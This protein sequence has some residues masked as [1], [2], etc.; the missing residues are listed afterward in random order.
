MQYMVIFTPAARFATEGLPP[1]F[2][3]VELEEQA[4][5]QAR[6]LYADGRLRQTWALGGPDQH[7][8]VVLFEA[9]DREDLEAAIVTFPFVKLDYCQYRACRWPRTR[10]SSRRA[11]PPGNREVRRSMR[12]WRLIVPSRCKPVLAALVHRSVVG[13]GA[14]D[15]G[16]APHVGGAKWIRPSVRSPSPGRAAVPTRSS[17]GTLTMSSASG[18]STPR[19]SRRSRR[20][21]TRT[22]VL[23]RVV[24]GIAV[25]PPPRQLVD[26][27]VR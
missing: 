3:D 2:W 26:L 24:S 11:G 12:R 16:A 21:S 27:K 6:V 7:G 15:H 17:L 22:D 4:Q 9:E 14:R 5:A 10:A 8:A 25:A 19:R 13:R 23:P 1:D 18:D 20:P